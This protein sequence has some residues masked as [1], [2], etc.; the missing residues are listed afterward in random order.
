M[1][2]FGGIGWNLFFVY[3]HFHLQTAVKFK[4]L[5]QDQPINN[6]ILSP[7]APQYFYKMYIEIY[8]RTVHTSKVFSFCTLAHPKLEIVILGCQQ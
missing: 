5:T 1:G 8:Q 7:I 4:L 3:F 6:F 2:R